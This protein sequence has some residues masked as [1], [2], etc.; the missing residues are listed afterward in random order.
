MGGRPLNECVRQEPGVPRVAD[1]RP[2]P[3]GRQP[4]WSPKRADIARRVRP[5]LRRGALCV[6]NGRQISRLR[7]LPCIADDPSFDGARR[8]ANGPASQGRHRAF[9]R[10]ST[11]SPNFVQLR[12]GARR[13]FSTV[14]RPAL[15]VSALGDSHCSF[16]GVLRASPG[17]LSDTEAS[18]D[19]GRPTPA[20]FFKFTG[21]A[22]RRAGAGGPFVMV[23]RFLSLSNGATGCSA[24]LI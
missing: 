11:A 6:C 2:L 8:T 9:A 13:R 17:A 20:P 7:V 18:H 24:R 14:T 12:R 16:R 5:G 23:P 15:H 10:S 3:V 1:A 21:G 4:A 22:R 19:C